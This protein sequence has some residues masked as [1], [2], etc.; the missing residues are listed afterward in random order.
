MNSDATAPM[1]YDRMLVVLHWVLALGLIFQLGLGVWMEEIPKDP[2]GT[3][4]LWFNLHKSIGICLGFLI[5]W[6]LG[7]RIT[8]SVPAPPTGVSTFQKTLGILNHR[9]LYV[10]MLVLPISGFMGSS[11]SPYPV[12]FFGVALPKLW[13]PSPEGKEIFSEVHEWTADVLMALL[14]LHIAAALWHQFVKRDGLLAR[15]GWSR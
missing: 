2:P 9:L 1:H 15:M 7:W 4:A 13:E 5:L 11:F 3:R 14:A 6:R 12:K 10:C 8:H